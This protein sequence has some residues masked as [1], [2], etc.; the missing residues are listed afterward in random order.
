MVKEFGN[1]F[2]Q[3]TL[4][5]F[6]RV[7]GCPAVIR[8]Y[9][10]R[11][12]GMTKQGKKRKNPTDL[13]VVAIS[14]DKIFAITCQEYI[15]FYGGKSGE[16]DIKRLVDNLNQ[17]IK[18][19]KDKIKNDNQKM[20]P[21]IAFLGIREENIKQLDDQAGK[22]IGEKVF[23][24]S[25]IDMPIS[26]IDK[27]NENVDKYRELEESWA[28]IEDFDWLISRIVAHFKVKSAELRSLII[29]SPRRRRKYKILSK[30]NIRN[31]DLK[32]LAP[33]DEIYNK[34]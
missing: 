18:D 22:I 21:V 9:N 26:F 3:F 19:I 31:L 23:L 8:D 27:W 13:D 2:E 28:S 7:V 15:P 29:N 16:E 20:I 34:I 1:Q 6:K 4:E 17:G 12:E 32:F 10:F 25:F 14:N 5:Y 11:K 24:I 33:F 30:D